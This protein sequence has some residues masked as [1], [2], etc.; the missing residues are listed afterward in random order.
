MVRMGHI[1]TVRFNPPA[2]VDANTEV[3]T[4]RQIRSRGG[5]AEFVLP[6]RLDFDLMLL[7][8]SGSAT[9][10]VDFREY[11]LS[12][13]DVLW[14][15]AGQVQQW[16]RITDI[17]GTVVLF[18]SHQVDPDLTERNH[19]P[20]ARLASAFAYL[21]SVDAETRS[22]AS[23]LRSSI[24]MHVLASIVLRLAGTAAGPRDDVF[25]WFRAEIG[26]RF[27]TLHKVSDYAARLGYSARTL[28]RA[29]RL[30]TG[31]SAKQLI[32]QRIVLEAKRLLAHLDDP[33][34][35]V[36]VRLGFDD[37]A[38]FTKYFRHLVGVTPSAF[39]Q[40]VRPEWTREMVSRGAPPDRARA[41]VR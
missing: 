30:N 34:A 10:A 29:A 39:R 38:N 32:D 28:N 17:E 11:R 12:A 4:L 8:S 3:T 9:H 20:D 24:L 5:P 22:L 33:V 18:E 36:A 25:G 6:Q 13:G 40:Q 41:E 19:W 7:V 21:A 31:L 23:S 35:D 2:G 26:Q 14:V 16:G 27:H 15:R 37:A 1:R